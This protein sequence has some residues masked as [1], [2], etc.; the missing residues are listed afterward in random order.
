MAGYTQC[1]LVCNIWCGYIGC[2]F[3][4][5][6]DG[7]HAPVY[8]DGL[9]TPVTQ[10]VYM[11]VRTAESMQDF[12]DSESIFSMFLN[13]SFAYGVEVSTGLSGMSRSLKG[14][15]TANILMFP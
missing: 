6:T 4:V 3:P 12:I 7:L 10:M 2:N 9:H 5:Y 11:H 8:S 14:L 13:N 15:I 1:K